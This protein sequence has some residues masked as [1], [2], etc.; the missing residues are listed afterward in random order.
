MTGWNEIITGFGQLRRQFRWGTTNLKRASWMDL[1]IPNL[2]SITLDPTKDLYV[3]FRFTL[4]GGGP[5]TIEDVQ[6]E[7]TQTEDALDPYLG[8][9][10]PMSVAERGNVSNMTKIENFTFKPYE[11]NPAVVLY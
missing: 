1:T 2:Q 11:V 8:F 10:P 3:D 9:H 5:I 4:I 7:Y 6:L